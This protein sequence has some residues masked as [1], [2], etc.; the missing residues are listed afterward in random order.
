MKKL[1]VIADWAEDTLAQSEVKIA[2]NGFLDTDKSADISFVHSQPSTF[3]TGFLLLQLSNTVERYGNPQNTVFF[4][5]TDPRNHTETGVRLSH[6]AK[7]V[8]ALLISGCYV[9]GPNA[10]YSFS[11]IKNKIKRLFYYQPLDKGSQFRSRD[12][13][14]R[15]ISAL[16]ESQEQDLELEEIDINNIPETRG[17]KVGHIDNYGNIKTTITLD[18]FK[19]KA[20]LN[21]EITVIINGIKQKAVFTDN[22]FGQEPNKL[23]IFPGSSGKPDNPFLEIA[24]RLDFDKTDTT[25]NA[26][27]IFKYPSPGDE[28]IIK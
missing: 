20:N 14:P 11:L 22:M 21:E 17:F 28:I 5:N 13:Y 7:G 23:V 10:G 8:I 15:I 1:I 2:I 26:A 24:V 4:V 3:H 6:G 12:N 18:D 9:I 19:G 25:N 27:S 16:L